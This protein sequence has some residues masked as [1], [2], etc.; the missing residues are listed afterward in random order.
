MKGSGKQ[1]AAETVHIAS[2]TLQA[3]TE[4]RV[5]P[6]ESRRRVIQPLRNKRRNSL[7]DAAHDHHLPQSRLD[8]QPGQNPAQRG[9][10]VVGVQSVQL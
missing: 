8:G 4:P 9:Q 3:D 5:N 6:T 1:E 10:L 2:P 7:E